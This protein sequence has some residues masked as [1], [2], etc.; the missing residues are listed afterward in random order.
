MVSRILILT[1]LFLTLIYHCILWFRI[2]EI[3][4]LK[5]SAV[6]YIVAIIMYVYI[7]NHYSL[8][9]PFSQSEGLPLAD[10][11]IYSVGA[12]QSDGTWS[13]HLWIQRVRNRRDTLVLKRCSRTM[14]IICDVCFF[15]GPNK[16]L[17]SKNRSL[18]TGA[19]LAGRSLAVWFEKKTVIESLS[20]YPLLEF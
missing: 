5:D 6:L 17:L 16:V 10:Y 11:S 2:Y 9:N 12:F 13:E 14:V 4:S 20:T 15:S 8:P 7:L 1:V 18:P 3:F 19:G